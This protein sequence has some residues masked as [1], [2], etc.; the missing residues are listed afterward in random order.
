MD[1]PRRQYWSERQWRETF[2]AQGCKCGYCG[3][4]AGPFEADHEIPSAFIGGLPTIILCVPCHRKK[5]KIDVRNI[6][7]VN[8]L[9]GN[10]QYDRRQRL[11]AEGKHK[12][13]S[14]RGFQ[15]N[16]PR[17]AEDILKGR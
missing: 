8:R 14:G 11:K 9:A 6:A 17:T 12:S 4:T 2:E 7:K 13:I 1:K 10:S 5:T 15:S 3:D 16:R